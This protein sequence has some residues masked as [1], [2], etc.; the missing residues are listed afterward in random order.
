MPVSPSQFMA[1]GASTTSSGFADALGRR[2]LAFDR[3]EGAMLER[4]A[5]RPELSAFEPMLR[6]RV[7]RVAGLEDERLARP[8]MVHRE[9]DGTLTVV[10]EFVPGSRLSDLL[11]IASDQAC[12]PGVDAAFGFLLD[13]L[14]ALCAL[15]AGAGF[16]HGA[17]SPARIVLTPAGQVVLLDAIYGGALE[18]LRYSRRTLWTDFGVATPPTAGA[19]RLDIAGD[20]AQL[21]LSA[22]MLVLGRPLYVDE[23]PAAVPRVMQE[24][25]EVAQ[26]RGS[27]PFAAAFQAFLQR[28]LPLANRQPFASADDA[29]IEIRSLA[30]ELGVEGCRR[31][32]VD[33]IQQ[34]EPS[35]SQAAPPVD[36][37]SVLSTLETYGLDEPGEGLEIVDP[38]LEE[39]EYQEEAVDP[40]IKEID[41]EALVGDEPPPD[42]QR[43]FDDVPVEHAAAGASG[44]DAP[45]DPPAEE[46]TAIPEPEVPAPPPSVRSKRARRTR[47]A[48]ARKDKLRSAAAPAPLL[49]EKPVPPK[50]A[51]ERRTTKE[52]AARAE[53]PDDRKGKNEEAPQGISPPRPVMPPKPTPTPSSG[54]WL[55]PPDRADAFAPPVPNEPIDPPFMPPRPIHVLTPPPPAAGIVAPPAPSLQPGIAPP[56]PGLAPLQSGISPPP[57]LGPLQSGNVLLPPPPSSPVPPPWSAAPPPAPPPPAPIGLALP[58][59]PAPMAPVKLKEPAHKPR[60]ARPAPAVADIYSAPPPP[61]SGGT[62]TSEFPW[63]LAVGALAATAVLIVGG[64]ALMTSSSPAAADDRPAVAATAPPSAQPKAAP[65]RATEAAPAPSAAAE[66][67]L[68][69]ETQPAGARVLIDGRPAGE[70]PLTLDKV[71]IGRHTVTL[72]SPAGTVKRSVRVEAGRTAKLDVPIF[73]GWVGI[74]APFVVEVAEAGRVIGTTEEPRIMLSPG[75]HELTLTNRELGFRAVEAVEIEPGE[76]RSVTLDPRGTVNLNASPWAEVWLD[77]KKLGDTPLA[78]LQLPLGTRELAFRH[79]DFGERLVTVTVKGNAPAAL[80]VDMTKR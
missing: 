16:P 50:V 5:V 58:Q 62:G 12:A 35:A 20:I 14:P 44:I 1:P 60:T 32:L 65:P 2:S 38:P 7:D 3:E 24:V 55:V 30:A 56:P 79:P 74:F 53:E 67:R 27:A 39:N 13:A 25:E 64:R 63:K 19:P 21:V 54:S 77:G 8:R 26:I 40:D 49:T 15:H 52:D 47:S 34:M 45:E 10:S 68:E 41:L 66:G 29:L 76:V 57:G 11:D 61:P 23:Y 37:D 9:A 28:G 6:E 59:A 48:R 75:R 31:A 36:L 69:V 73:S 17:L 80:S 70:S 18:H 78:G 46:H 51:E 43:E 72:I 22:M 33:F 42:I 4:L 71:P